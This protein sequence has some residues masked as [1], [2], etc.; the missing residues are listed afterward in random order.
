MKCMKKISLLSMVIAISSASLINASAPASS[1]SS[2]S[3]S[4]RQFDLDKYY[5]DTINSFSALSK[6]ELIKKLNQCTGDSSWPLR[7][8]AITLLIEKY[9][10]NPNDIQY[11]DHDTPLFEPVLHNDLPFAQ[12]LL[13]HNANANGISHTHPILSI[14]I[15]YYAKTKAMADL[16]FQYGAQV[17]EKPHN[18][19]LYN[20]IVQEH[21][22]ELIPLFV[23]KGAQVNAQNDYGCTALLTLSNGNPALM[24]KKLLLYTQYLLEAGASITAKIT[25]GAYIGYTAPTF[26]KLALDEAK[27]KNDQKRIELLQQARDMM[28]KKYL[29]SMMYDSEDLDESYEALEEVPEKLPDLANINIAEEDYESDEDLEQFPEE[30][31]QQAQTSSA[32]SSSAASSS[33]SSSTQ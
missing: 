28:R 12:F 2:S 10:M 18:P 9:I 23:Q 32:S 21:E 25:Y 14:P 16:L 22:P 17:I 3:S 24:G 19:I 30:Q 4:F 20:V 6:D 11:D 27:K 33:S 29:E 8:G 15:L 31:A 1:S 26:L 13:A 7:K 5:Q